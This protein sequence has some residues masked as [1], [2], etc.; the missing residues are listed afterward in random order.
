MN[1][2]PP[3]IDPLRILI[4]EDEMMVALDLE[5]MIAEFGHE[6]AATAMR[7]EAA[8]DHARETPI[9]FAIL[10]VNVAGRMS[11]PVAEALM[12][13]GVPFIFATGYGVSVLPERL[14]DQKTLQKPFRR[15]DL[16]SAIAAHAARS[17]RG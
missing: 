11:F 13:R 5:D 6:V 1:S 2:N 7:I 8:L 12:E 9:D 17:A 10:D 3:G 16:Q 4:V 14:K 15:S